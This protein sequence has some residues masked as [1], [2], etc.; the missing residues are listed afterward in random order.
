[1]H[2]F[3]ERFEHNS[4]FTDEDGWMLFRL[5]AFGEAIGWTLLITGIGLSRYVFANNQASIVIAGR[6]HGVLF[7]AYVT[8]AVGLYP[9]LKWS[10]TKAF[11]ALLVSVIPYGS[12]IFERWVHGQRANKSYN[13]FKC[14]VAYKLLTSI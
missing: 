7:L 9:T 8:A 2:G 13:D 1:M 6:L 12:L 3:L 10:R 4:V 14:I 11:F 5:A